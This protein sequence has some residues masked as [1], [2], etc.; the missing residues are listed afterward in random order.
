MTT[1]KRIDSTTSAVGA[2]LRV[3]YGFRRG[4]DISPLRGHSPPAPW[5][6]CVGGET[7]VY[8]VPKRTASPK[9]GIASTTPS[10]SRSGMAESVHRHAT[11]CD[12]S[13]LQAFRQRM[14]QKSGPFLF[15]GVGNVEETKREHRL[16]SIGKC[17]CD[18]AVG[19]IETTRMGLRRWCE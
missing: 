17:V 6:D 14:A 7:Q 16:R 8:R 15:I 9:S 13:A 10:N 2:G 5:W 12:A 19:N 1:M 18:A 11:R 3:G 4:G